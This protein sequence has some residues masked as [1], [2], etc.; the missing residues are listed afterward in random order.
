[1]SLLAFITVALGCKMY[2]NTVKRNEEINGN[3][4]A[5]SSL[6]ELTSGLAQQFKKYAKEKKRKVEAALRL[7]LVSSSSST[8]K[9]VEAM[10]YSLLSDGKRIRPV[11]CLCSCEMFGGTD[12]AAL[13][14][15][16]SLEMI[17]TMSMIHDDLY[18]RDTLRR[19]KPTNHLVFGEDVAILAGDALLSTSF[20]YLTKQSQSVIS[21]ECILRIVKRLGS[22]AGVKGLAGGQVKEME[23]NR[24]TKDAGSTTEQQ[25]TLEQIE[26]LYMHRT[27][28]LLK[29]SV[30]I[31]AI[32]AGASEEQVADCELFAE[33][34]GFAFQINDDIQNAIKKAATPITVSSSSSSGESPT[35]T[36]MLSPPPASSTCAVPIQHTTYVS[37]VGIAAAKA[38][39]AA[40]VQ[41]AAAAVS[42]YGERSAALVGIT[43]YMFPLYPIY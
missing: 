28:A 34:I 25:L 37:L 15:A 23:Y 22:A 16:V 43:D 20:E 38:K 18:R 41:E 11:L 6:Q 1:M 17:H 30:A 10:R 36:S 27:A 4:S 39:V 2:Q 24:V 40:L 33:K 7:S 12:E 5:S 26:W 32:I 3:I 35:S 21:A 9:I 19:R 13:P 29:A 31:G 8:T 14:A 42:I